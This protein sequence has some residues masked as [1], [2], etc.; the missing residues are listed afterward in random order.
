MAGGAVDIGTRA[1]QVV[2]GVRQ[3]EEHGGSASRTKARVRGRNE[4]ELLLS[5]DPRRDKTGGSVAL[6]GEHVGRWHDTVGGGGGLG[7]AVIALGGGVAGTVGFL[8]GQASG[9]FKSPVGCTVHR[10]R[11]GLNIQIDFQIKF[12]KFESSTSRTPNIFKLWVM[13]DKFKGNIF[14]FAKKSKFPTELEL[15]IREAK[16]S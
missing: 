14:P 5:A 4:L 9:Q 2:H 3:R 16:Q 15:K 13:V 7:P 10:G 6:V 12:A 11:P 1:R 8:V